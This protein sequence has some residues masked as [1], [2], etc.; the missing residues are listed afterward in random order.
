MLHCFQKKTP[1]TSPRDIDL[2]RRR[3]QQ[4]GE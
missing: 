1:K 2:A 3:Y 4:I